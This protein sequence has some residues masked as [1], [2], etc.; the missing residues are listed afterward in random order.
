MVQNDGHQTSSD[1]LLQVEPADGA[2]ATAASCP[3]EN[4]TPSSFGYYDAVYDHVYSRGFPS[5]LSKR[6]GSVEVI[7]PT[8]DASPFQE[9]H[10]TREHSS[11]SST[12]QTDE[13][14]AIMKFLTINAFSAWRTVNGAKAL[15][16]RGGDGKEPYANVAGLMLGI[17]HFNN[18]N[19]SVVK[20]ITDIHNRCPV[21][22]A[23][24]DFF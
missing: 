12:T 7:Q 22:F 14:Y 17:H 3:T 11:S 13:T 18:G 1:R 21:R 6:V 20:E 9:E 19:G 5:E 10:A 23:L 2:A 24:A 4:L 8:S 16:P 15:V